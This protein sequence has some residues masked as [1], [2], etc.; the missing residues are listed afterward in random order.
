MGQHV[1]ENRSAGLVCEENIE[2]D[3]TSLTVSAAYWYPVEFDGFVARRARIDQDILSAPDEEQSGAIRVEGA[4]KY[5]AS[6]I[7]RH[8]RIDLDFHS[9]VS[10]IM[11][12]GAHEAF[13]KFR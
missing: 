3:R 10:A 5:A 9:C 4:E 1:A 2:Q 7:A 6:N 11:F 8:D 12:V 13:S